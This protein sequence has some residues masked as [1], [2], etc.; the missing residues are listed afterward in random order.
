MANNGESR[1]SDGALTGTT[2]RKSVHLC[3]QCGAITNREEMS[4]D[5]M[6]TGVLQCR[7]CRHSGPLNVAIVAA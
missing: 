6:I 2:L 3:V 4:E 7:E 5:A 1:D